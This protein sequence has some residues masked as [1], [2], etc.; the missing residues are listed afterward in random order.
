MRDAAIYV[1]PLDSEDIRRGMEV[2]VERGEEAQLAVR[3]GLE[4]AR[5]YRWSKVA[6][7]TLEV[8]R[9]ILGNTVH[10]V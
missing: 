3:R 8:Y 10:E 5:E 9:S 6:A 4:V 7:E 2:A 1:N